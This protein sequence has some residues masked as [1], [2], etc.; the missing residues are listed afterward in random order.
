MSSAAFRWFCEVGHQVGSQL[1]I[2]HHLQPQEDHIVN[3]WS[4]FES[5][6]L[7]RVRAQIYLIVVSTQPHILSTKLW[8]PETDNTLWRTLKHHQWQVSNK[9]KCPL[10]KPQIRM[11]HTFIAACC[12]TPSTTR[13]KRE[14][15]VQRS[16]LW[17]DQTPRRLQDYQ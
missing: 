9:T 1:G 16:A 2:Q 11:S 10:E 6:E 17:N 14:H 5:R 7:V 12:S 13:W 4:T 3:I 15:L 8:T